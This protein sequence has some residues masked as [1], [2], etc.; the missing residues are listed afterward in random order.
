MASPLVSD[1]LWALIEPLLP[2]EP[3]KPKGGRPR[4]DNRAALTGI[5]FVLRSGIPWELLPVEMGCGSGMTCWRRLHEWQQAG[6]WERLHRVLL[7]RLGYANAINWDRAAVDSASVPG[8]KGGE[9]TGPNPTDRG[10]PGSKRHIL[11]DANGIPLAL[12]IS[13]ANRHDSKFLEAL[14]DAV[15]AIRQCAGRP[16]R[17]PAKLHADKGYDFAHC[18]QALRRRGIIPRIARRGIES[19]ERLGRHRWVVERTLAWFARFRRIAVR[20][21]RRADIFTAFHHIAASL[22]CWRFVQRWFC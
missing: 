4:L 14:V 10:K 12:R 2:P 15:P 19:S 21:E 13:P 6:V 22:I 17:R 11:V 16:R 9:E 1:A 20:Y 7:D 5:L 3:P 8:K 18:R